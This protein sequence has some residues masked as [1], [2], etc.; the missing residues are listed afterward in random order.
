MIVKTSRLK[1]LQL[2][3]S[4]TGHNDQLV[5]QFKTSFEVI[6]L[7]THELHRTTFIENLRSQKYGD[8]NVIIRPVVYS[9]TETEP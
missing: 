8:F 3:T 1:V 6:P 4:W 2:G 9:G 5:K 7:E